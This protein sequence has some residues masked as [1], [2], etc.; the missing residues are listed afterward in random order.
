MSRALFLVARDVALA[1]SQEAPLTKNALGG[2]LGP[3]SSP[4]L[5]S[6]RRGVTKAYP[7]LLRPRR[8]AARSAQTPHAHDMELVARSEPQT[9]PRRASCECVRVR[10]KKNRAQPSV[11]QYNEI[12]SVTK[13]NYLLKD[14]TVLQSIA[15]PLSYGPKTGDI[16]ES[17]GSIGT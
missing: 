6:A 8:G 17:V 12:E 10:C 5:V 1:G 14:A 13:F 4:S 15:L 16:G 7:R 11:R 9:L 3:Y 2:Q